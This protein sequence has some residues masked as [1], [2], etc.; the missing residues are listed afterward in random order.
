[1]VDPADGTVLARRRFGRSGPTVNAASPLVFGDYA[2]LTASYQVG[3][4]LLRL[5]ND[6]WETVWA[7]DDTLSS[8]YNTP[9]EADGFLYGIHGREDLGVAE[10]R[11]VE[12]ATGRVTWNEPGF[13]VAHLLR[14]DNRLLIL[15]VTG[16][17]LLAQVDSRRFQPLAELQVS[18]ATTRALPALSEGRLFVRETS[19]TG[20][21]L[22][23][24]DLASD[25]K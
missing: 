5:G 23:C 21:R 12:A 7:N 10:L 19:G 4:V 24:L 1:M 16:K 13:G 20:G 11:C 6:Q 22:I 3:A 18:P 15:K 9:V 8:Q 14:V 25:A 17:L 2:F